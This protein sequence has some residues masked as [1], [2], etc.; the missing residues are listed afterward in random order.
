MEG[1]QIAYRLELDEPTI[2]L[3]KWQRMNPFMQKKHKKRLSW[4][5]RA[6]IKQPPASPL[7]RA[8]IHV[9]RG[10]PPPRPDPDGLIGGLKPLL[11][12]LSCP[13]GRK[14]FGMGFIKDDS[15]LFLK[16]LTAESVITKRGQ[17]FTTVEIWEPAPNELRNAA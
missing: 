8:R 6:A 2:L 3:N 1:W 15:P 12:V 17:G 14:P 11:D 13:R 5:V 10:N 4:L 7:H 9:I 16:S